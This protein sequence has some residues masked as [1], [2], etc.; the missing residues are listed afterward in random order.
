M[1]IESEIIQSIHLNYIN[2]P[3]QKSLS[4]AK[5]F[6]GKQ[7]PLSSVYLTCVR[8]ETSSHI[9]GEGYT[10]A[11]RAGGKSQYELAKE[12]AP[13]LL[14][15][16]PFNISYLWDKLH[17]CGNTL[18]ENGIINQVIA[19]FDTALWD[20]KTKKAGLP[21]SQLI[22]S[23]KSS[24]SCYNTTAGYLS[25]KIDEVINKAKELLAN[26]IGG[27]KLKVGQPDLDADIFRVRTLRDKLGPNVPIMVDANQQWNLETALRFGKATED[28][29]LT[30][31]EE[32]LNAYDL[33]GHY[34]LT[35]RLQVPIGTG[36][37]LSSAADLLRYIDH[38]AVN[39]I[40]PDAPRIGGITPFLKVLDRAREKRLAVAPHFVM[41]MHLPLAATYAGSIWVEHIDWLKDLFNE[42]VEIADGS[43]KVPK[44]IGNG[45]SFNEKNLNLF[46]KEDSIYSLD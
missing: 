18:S 19:A 5:V 11:L 28:C 15:E 32:P 36:E 16:N 34:E 17:W 27:I 4:D 13:A 7:K 3:L 43:M 12:L 29:N 45:F 1:M 38:N 20:I 31:L 9:K 41:E 14:G 10:Y 25:F 24:I 2:V 35:H 42:Q 39:L 22:G 37:M 6:Q 26:G 33:E 46:S 30:W 8:M 44:R 21:I 40:M 23:Y